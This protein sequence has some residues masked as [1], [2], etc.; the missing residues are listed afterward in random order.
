MRILRVI[1]LLVVHC[2]FSELIAQIADIYQERVDPRIFAICRPINGPFWA[3]RT[4][5]IIAAQSIEP[6]L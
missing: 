6:E 5:S 4:P 3:T 2:L 1:V